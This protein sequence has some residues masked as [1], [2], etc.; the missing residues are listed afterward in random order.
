MVDVV[1]NGDVDAN[2]T[3]DCE[4]NVI[5]YD[6]M[7]TMMTHVPMPWPITTHALL[8]CAGLWQCI[9]PTFQWTN[10]HCMAYYDALLK[11]VDDGYSQRHPHQW[12]EARRIRKREEVALDEIQKKPKK[13]IKKKEE[14]NSV[15]IKKRRKVITIMGNWR[16]KKWRNEKFFEMGGKLE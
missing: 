12:N 13:I 2:A 8:Q 16:G 10:Q 6:M 4:T 15:Q 7:L 9:T 11:H 3:H 14:K 5:T 1:D